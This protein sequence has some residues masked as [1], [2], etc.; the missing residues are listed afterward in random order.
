MTT[1]GLKYQHSVLEQIVTITG[2]KYQHSVLEQTITQFQIFLSSR[3]LAKHV[4]IN[5][6]KII[7][8]PVVW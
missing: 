6:Q 2:F 7:S 3:S 1:T 5:I 8:L 4:K